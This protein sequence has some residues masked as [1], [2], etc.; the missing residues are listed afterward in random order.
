MNIN[1]QIY[2]KI[3]ENDYQIYNLNLII[4]NLE[5]EIS[6]KLSFENELKKFELILRQMNLQIYEYIDLYND[7]IKINLKKSSIDINNFKW[8][9][10]QNIQINNWSND[11]NLIKLNNL[12]KE[13]KKLVI[14]SSYP[15]DISNL[16]IGLV[17]LDLSDSS[18]KF[19]LDNLPENLKLL[20]VD[21]NYI[22]KKIYNVDDF[23]N[24]PKKLKRINLRDKVYTSVEQIIENY[25][26]NFSN[27]MDITYW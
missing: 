7:C 26:K 11:Y 18:Y 21:C 1:T 4:T 13:L 22:G 19:N 2:N 8:I 27:E 12:P 25:E 3:I 24:L 14:S 20:K 17:E 9:K 16:P 15:F 6:F 23:A 10:V 5:L